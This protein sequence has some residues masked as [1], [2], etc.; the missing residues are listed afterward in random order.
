M[1]T[2]M[3]FSFRER[4]LSGDFY[5]YTVSSSY[6]IILI[7]YAYGIPNLFNSDYEYHKFSVNLQQWFNFSTIGWSK[8]AIEAGKTWGILPYPL[9]KIHDG[10]ETF[11]YDEFASNLMNYYEFAS[12]QYLS[13]IWT[14]HFDGLLLNH[15]P[16]IRKLKWRE[17]AHL[18][19][20]YGTLKDSNLEY[21]LF[22]G[23]M[24]SFGN[25]P[26]WEAGVGIENI[27][28]IVRVDAIWRLNHLDDRLNPN[29]TKF[30][31]F[32]SLYF[33]F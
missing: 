30:G 26:Y 12:D 16:L 18:R 28:R 13:V 6:P 2:P 33:S 19:C 17:V 11:L 22:P 15:I 1:R 21:S 9:L 4:F 20:V 3:F 27:F 10:N 31:V 32:V 8:Y 23:Q 25:I 7:K 29:A 24:R 14:H 5:R